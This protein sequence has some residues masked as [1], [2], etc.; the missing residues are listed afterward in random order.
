MSEQH[1]GTDPVP[2]GPPRRQRTSW[3]LGAVAATVAV[4]LSVA[5]LVVALNRSSTP[6]ATTAVSGTQSCS[7][8]E[9]AR[10]GMFP[11]KGIGAHRCR[12]MPSQRT[13]LR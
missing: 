8:T 7:A 9:V 2:T 13:S 12:W 6:S 10:S 3:L 4:G 11:A 5:G 1:V